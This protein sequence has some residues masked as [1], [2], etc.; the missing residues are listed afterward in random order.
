MILVFNGDGKGKVWSYDDDDLG[1]DVNVSYFCDFRIFY[2]MSFV[3]CIY[4]RY[5]IHTMWQHAYIVYIRHTLNI[6]YIDGDSSQ[7]HDPLVQEKNQRLHAS[8]ILS[9]SGEGEGN[10]CVHVHIYIHI[11]IF[12]YYVFT[13]LQWITSIFPLF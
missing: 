5:S 13:Y 3:L 12:T 9:N 10:P 7:R 1:W 6:P 4:T 8:L 11:Y 2:V